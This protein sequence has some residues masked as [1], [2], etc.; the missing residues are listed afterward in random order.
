MD[1]SVFTTGTACSM[2]S[3]YMALRAILIA[4]PL[5]CRQYAMKEP[6]GHNAPPKHGIKDVRTDAELKK[7]WISSAHKWFADPNANSELLYS[8]SLA[9]SLTDR[10]LSRKC[11]EEARI[12]RKRKKR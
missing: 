1:H 7:W 11:L 12:R 8:A 2:D 9:L 3:L 5:P 10:E 4:A 6:T